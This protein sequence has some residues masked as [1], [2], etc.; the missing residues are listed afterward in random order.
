M[1]HRELILGVLATQA[2]FVTPAQFV[3]AASAWLIEKV[4]PSVLDRL[5]RSGAVTPEQ[6]ALLESMADAASAPT[7]GARSRVLAAQDEP[8]MVSLGSGTG[9]FPREDVRSGPELFSV[10][11]EREGQYVRLEEVGRGGHSIVRRALDRF[12]GREVALKELLPGSND[13]PTPSSSAVGARFLREVRLIAL[14][15]HPGIVAVHEVAQR[16][17]GTLFCAEELIRGE[18]LKARLARC[19]SLPQR[20]KLLPHL[21]DACQA[22]AYAHARGVIHRDLKPANIMVGP[23]GETVVIDWG[24]ATRR[25]EA[26]E[27]GS[28]PAPQTRSE[29]GLTVAGVALGTPSYMSPEQAR[30]AL[31]EI[32]ERSDV[33]GLGAILYEVLCGRPP[34]DGATNEHILENVRAGQILPTRLACAEVP[35]ELAA[36]AERALQRAPGTRYPSADALAKDLL[37]YRAG[38]RVQSYEYPPWELVRKF[39]G[40]RRRLS[41][42][43]GVALMLLAGSSVNTW[44]HRRLSQVTSAASLVERTPGAEQGTEGGRATGGKELSG[45]SCELVKPAADTR[46]GREGSV[47]RPLS[48]SGGK[49]AATIVDGAIT[50]M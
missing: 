42:A 38:D 40:R 32:D 45:L 11:L 50:A 8:T 49:L 29:P 23:F 17:D 34:F 47:L 48:R 46:K 37:A 7:E 39:C 35:P 33:F 5:E 16:A 12:T 13:Q 31:T 36:I 44:W 24:L 10:P 27:T 43:I 9:P 15:E 18:T 28:A 1:Q 2:R 19:K 25:G 3:D 22:I 26:E 14:L 4:G 21:V 20:L 6:R 30:G 41:V